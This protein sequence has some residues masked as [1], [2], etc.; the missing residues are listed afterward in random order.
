MFIHKDIQEVKKGGTNNND[1][2]GQYRRQNWLDPELKWKGDF[3]FI[4]WGY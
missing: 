3:H 1:Y 4:F 2:L